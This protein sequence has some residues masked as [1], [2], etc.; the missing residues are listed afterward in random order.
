MLLTRQLERHPRHTIHPYQFHIHSRGSQ[1]HQCKARRLVYLQRIRMRKY[2]PYH[3][4]DLLFGHG[5]HEMIGVVHGEVAQY[6]ASL[7]LDGGVA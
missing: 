2:P 7:R 4:I 6:D 5:G 1:T 3:G